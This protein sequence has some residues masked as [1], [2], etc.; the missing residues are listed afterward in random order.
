M[1]CGLLDQ[2][3]PFPNANHL[4]DDARWITLHVHGRAVAIEEGLLVPYEFLY[5][6]KVVEVCFT[7]RLYAKYG[8]SP[9]IMKR[10]VETGLDLLSESHRKDTVNLRRRVIREDDILVVQDRYGITFMELEDW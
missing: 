8:A 1:S 5:N 3:E 10:I 6:G 4:D 2:Y 7:D 9:V